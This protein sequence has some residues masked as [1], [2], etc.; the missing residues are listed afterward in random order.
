MLNL[1]STTGVVR[2]SE[3]LLAKLDSDVSGTLG[4]L[5]AVGIVTYRDFADEYRI[6]QGTDID[7]KG[8][9]DA[10][11]QR[12]QGQSLVTLLLEVDHPEPV[13]AA[14]HSAQH[15]LLRVFARRYVDDGETATPL[16]AFAP[17]DGEVLLVV[18][19]AGTLPALSQSSSGAKPVVAA[20]PN[21][22]TVLEAAAQEASAVASVL[23]ESAVERDWVAKRELGERLA[24]ARVA[25]EQ[26]INAAFRAESCQWMLLDASGGQELSGHRGTAALSEACDL[27][28]PKTPR[29]R[30]EMLSRTAV[31]SQG[32]KARRL[33]LAGMIERGS[34]AGLGL[35]GYGPEVAMYRA[36]L[37]RT[38]L[39]GEAPDSGTIGH[40]R[41]SDTSLQ[42]AWDVVEKEFR[43][44]KTRRINLNDIYAALTSPPVGMKLGAIPVFV[45]AALLARSEVIAIYE[46]GTFKPLLTPELSERM[47]RNPGHFE[48]KHFAHT[49]GARRQVVGLLADHLGVRPAFA[50]HRVRN[51]LAVVGHLI[52][53][54][55]RLENYTLRTRSLSPE[56]SGVRN[57]L[58]TAVEPDDLLFNDLP[59][60]LGF[61]VVHAMAADY[62]SARPYS[63]ALREALDELTGCYQA[64]LRELFRSLLQTSGETRRLAVAGQAAALDQEV[65]NP[66][67]RSFV[68]ILANDGVDTDADWIAAIATVVSKKA[69]AEWTDDD[70]LRF[71]HELSH[72]ISAFQRLLALHVER[73]AEGGGPFDALRVTVTRPDGAEH[74]RLVAV[75]EREQEAVND[76][77]DETLNDLITTMGSR[78][79]AHRALLA[80]LGERLLSEGAEGGE[81]IQ[82]KPTQ[83]PARHA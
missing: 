57:A 70:R 73:R 27:A 46:H 58:V 20:V 22:V 55:R 19:S 61:G 24:E 41:P 23:K 32:A 66:E 83:R 38:G 51:V 29:I 36:F 65:L 40:K 74:A 49:T 77:L 62:V 33:L 81:E 45:T 8:L 39:H 15:D 31:T 25:L 10:A 11:R 76:A 78:Q 14:R 17:Y 35:V 4:E 5:E 2:A 28:Y 42:A 47:V 26:A 64:L 9:L 67:V 13:V 6:W 69:P 71:R 48:V 68:G 72:Q 12:A 3:R 52:S 60:T 1:V 37:E 43:R 82:G 75:D 18:G 34:E 63:E 53:Q 30:N 7:I 21:D 80:V 79:R 59:K 44:G 16:H 54:I 50:G 56:A